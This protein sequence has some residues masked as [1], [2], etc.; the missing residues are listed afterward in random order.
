MIQ[1]ATASRSPAT[2][3]RPADPRRSEGAGRFRQS[4]AA[5]LDAGADDAPP[6]AANQPGN[7]DPAADGKP[8]PDAAAP[9]ALA[10]LAQLPPIA[11]PA[12]PPTVAETQSLGA[13]TPAMVLAAAPTL[14]APMLELVSAVAVDAPAIDAAKLE[15]ADTP[16]PDAMPDAVTVDA[17]A[18]PAVPDVVP[19]GAA[20]A[21]HVFSA[22]IRAAVGNDADAA[23]RR[24]TA[25]AGPMSIGAVGLEPQRHAVAATGDVQQAPLDARQGDFPHRMI[26]RIEQLRD[27][28]NAS[29]TRIR[30]IPDALGQIDVTMR[31][32]GDA[33]HVHFAA[34]QGATRALLENARTELAD[35]AAS[36]GITLGQTSVGADGG[37]QQRQ[38]PAPSQ[39]PQ[40]AAAP[41]PSAA[42]TPDDIRIA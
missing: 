30:L 20:P 37:S 23:P 32:D 18:V 19:R 27:D 4:L 35:I 17:F 8:L 36:R 12:P 15:T 33:V 11:Q 26:D 2:P 39:Q 31:R 9:P 40:R 3:D 29:N 1:S 7:D 14:V 42:Q 6:A 28:A 21:A 38:A 16:L 10:W 24:E 5:F 25:N 41:T 13:A 34:E 22:A